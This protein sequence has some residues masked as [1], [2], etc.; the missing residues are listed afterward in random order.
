MSLSATSMH[1]MEKLVPTNTL[2]TP[3]QLFVAIA[4]SLAAASC[5]TNA[6]PVICALPAS[7][8]S[9]GTCTCGSGTA[10]CPVQPGPEFLYA[11]TIGGQILAFSIDPNNN[12]AL[13]PIG[14]VSGPSISLG[15]TS[16][17]NQF[18]YASDTHNAQIDGFSINQT[19]GALTALAGSPFS[20]GTL[21]L[22]GVLA[23]PPGDLASSPGSSLL[24]AADSGTIDMFTINAGGV[25]TALSGSPYVPEA[26]FAIVVDPSGRY[27]YAS[28]D[29]PPGGVF[30]FTTDSAGALAPI[31][32]SPFTIPGQTVADSLPIGIVD[33]GSYVY[34]ALSQTNQIAAFSIASVAGALTGALAPVPNSP[35]PAGTAPTAVVVAGN[36]LYAINSSN[37]SIS[38]DGTISGYS[39]NSSNGMLTPLSGSPFAIVGFSL[40]TDYLGQH[41][42]VSGLTGIQAFSI[43]FTSGALTPVSGSPF[44]AFGATLLTVVQIPPP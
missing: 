5:G 33:T 32:D 20:T 34:A 24:Y 38:S 7:P 6:P 27:F 14:S 36:F 15:L 11:T 23:S 1:F 3:A 35:F 19:T 17:S 2:E 22:P 41:L 10:A 43:D 4:L 26:G 29:D 31:P 21:S 8:S 12:G 18:L 13:T 28:D 25:P 39:I 37:G 9:S 42:Y 44:P 16:V 40:A 30:A